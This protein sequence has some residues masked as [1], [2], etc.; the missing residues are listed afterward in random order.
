MDKAVQ[1]VLELGTGIEMAKFDLC[2][3]LGVLIAAHKTECLAT[4]IIFLGIEVHGW[5]SYLTKN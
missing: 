5:S 2:A 1:K 4:R 3:R